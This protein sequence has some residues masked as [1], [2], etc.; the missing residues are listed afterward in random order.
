MLIACIFNAY[1]I[2]YLQI[3][4]NGVA[5][6]ILLVVDPQNGF[7]PGQTGEL[8]VPNGDEIVPVVNKLM[9]SGEYDLVVATQD[10]HPADHGS[11]AAN[12]PGKNPGEEIILAGEK[13]ILWSTHC[14]QNTPSAEFHP[15][16]RTDLID[17]VVQ[18]GTDVNVDSYSGFYDNAHIHSTGLGS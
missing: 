3:A 11:F 9:E 16:L 5:M 12:H 14:V 15:D 8:P 18:K 7:C 2:Y 17:A 10:W 4:L 1:S 13:Q 6:K